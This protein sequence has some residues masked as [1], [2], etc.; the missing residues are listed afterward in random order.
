[1]PLSSQLLKRAPLP[2][3]R[4]ARWVSLSGNDWFQVKIDME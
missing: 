3:T 2:L 1:L 4:S